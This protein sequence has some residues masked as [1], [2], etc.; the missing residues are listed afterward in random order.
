VVYVQP[1]TPVMPYPAPQPYFPQPAPPGL[2]GQ[3]SF[4]F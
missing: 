3:F 2:H 1:V 4:G